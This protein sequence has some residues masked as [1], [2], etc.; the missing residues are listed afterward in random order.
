MSAGQIEK[1]AERWIAE[2]ETPPIELI[3]LATIR[4]IHPI[5]IFNLLK[6]VGG[7]VPPLRYMALSL[8]LCGELLE[9]NKLTLREVLSWLWKLHDDSG[10]T[11]D[12]RNMIYYLDDAYDLAMQGYGGSLEETERELR[13]FVR[14]YVSTLPNSVRELLADKPGGLF[15]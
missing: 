9:R 13:D 6:S 7:N 10:V 2:L 15:E 4:E 14:P 11:E 3:D 5:D 8:G 1:W 12:E